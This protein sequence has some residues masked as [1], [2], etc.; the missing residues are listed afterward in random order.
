MLEAVLVIGIINLVV[1]IVF[2]VIAAWQRHQT[3]K[4]IR[5]RDDQG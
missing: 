3:I 2:G 5:G 4:G 1:G